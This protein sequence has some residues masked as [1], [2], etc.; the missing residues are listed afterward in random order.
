MAKRVKVFAEIEPE[1]KAKAEKLFLSLGFPDLSTA[2]GFFLRKSVAE[3]RFPFDVPRMPRNIDLNQ[4]TREELE[5]DFE[6]ALAQI[7]RGEGIPAEEMKKEIES[8][9]KEDEV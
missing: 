4:M 5:A 6:I 3:N 2:I 9:F 7:E 8:W 1:I